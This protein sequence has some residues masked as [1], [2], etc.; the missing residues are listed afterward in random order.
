MPGGTSSSSVD[1]R[2]FQRT[3]SWNAMVPPPRL[4]CVIIRLM[5]P[6]QTQLFFL[7]IAHF[8]WSRVS[9]HAKATPKGRKSM[10]LMSYVRCTPSLSSIGGIGPRIHDST[11]RSSLRI[12]PTR[13]FQK[14]WFHF[15]F[16]AITLHFIT[17]RDL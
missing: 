7:V 15:L 3:G 14:S 10:Y 5:S 1:L 6:T 2:A 9:G 8:A 11:S 17:P 13:S 12:G 4:R 16:L